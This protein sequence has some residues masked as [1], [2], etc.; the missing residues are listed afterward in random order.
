M[1]YIVDLETIF[2]TE[3]VGMYTTYLQ[4]KFDV[5]NFSVLLYVVNKPKAKYIFPVL[6]YYIL[7]IEHFHKTFIFFKDLPPYVISGPI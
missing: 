5:P 2:I 7:Q 6:L 1:F 3:F 4:T